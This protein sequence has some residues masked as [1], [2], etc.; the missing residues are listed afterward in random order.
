MKY[1]NIIV[2]CCDER[3]K[4]QNYNKALIELKRRVLAHDKNTNHRKLNEQRQI[5]IGCGQRGDK[6]RTYR[7][8]DNIIIDHKSGIK[9]NYLKLSSKSLLDLIY[10]S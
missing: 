3:S 7:E 1:D 2:T 8:K 6:I 9:Y 4:L 10:V 5:Q